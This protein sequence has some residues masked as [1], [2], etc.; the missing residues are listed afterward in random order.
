MMVRG[1]AA[2]F[3]FMLA[4]AGCGG[5][6]EEATEAPKM[7]DVVGRKLDV[8]L[9]E[10][11]NAGI[12][13]E[14][15]ILGGGTFGI[16]DESNWTV[17]EQS[18]AAGQDSRNAPELTV[19]RSCDDDVTTSTAPAAETTVAPDVPEAPTEEVLTAATNPEFAAL[20]A[21]NDCSDAVEAFGV[22]YSGRTIEFDGH[23]ADLANHGDYDT[24]FDILMYAG[25]FDP[26][27]ARGPSFQFRNVSIVSDL[28]LEGPNIS[29]SLR[30]GDNLRVVAKIDGLERRTCLFL[31]EP[32]STAVR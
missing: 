27:S 31:L 11:K 15:D 30:E 9:A 26:S 28:N 12:G 21:G 19:D 3:A 25:D 8:A 20:L 23:I 22:K 13:D 29:D 16:V 10:I 7:P 1:V 17:C 4:A 32:V 24:R 18:P 2:A 6:G 5:S 14:P